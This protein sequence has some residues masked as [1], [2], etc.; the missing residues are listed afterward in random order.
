MVQSSAVDYLHCLLVS[1]AW[2]IKNFNL[3]AR[4]CISIH[5]EVRYLCDERCADQ[6][7][8]ALQVIDAISPLRMYQM[9]NWSVL[10]HSV[11]PEGI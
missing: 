11:Q 4:I 2:L 6:V 7:A 3:R 8:L 1:M 10:H 5:D 9:T